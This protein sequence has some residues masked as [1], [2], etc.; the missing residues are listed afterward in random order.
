MLAVVSDRKFGQQLYEYTANT[1]NTG[2]HT[3]NTLANEYIFIGSGGNFDQTSST[4]ETTFDVYLPEVMSY[5]DYYPFGVE[6]YDRKFSVAATAYG[7]N[8]QRKDNEIYGEGNSY[9]AEFWQYDSRLGRRWN[10]DP[11]TYPTHSAY[12]T[13]NNNPIFYADP[14]GEEGEPTKAE[15]ETE[16][17]PAGEVKNVIMAFI[18]KLEQDG[19]LK[20]NHQLIIGG[21]DK[22]QIDEDGEICTTQN[23]S[24]TY[25]DENG[26]STEISHDGNEWTTIT[27]QNKAYHQTSIE[28]AQPVTFGNT[29]VRKVGLPDWLMEVLDDDMNSVHLAIWGVTASMWQEAAESAVK[30][31]GTLKTNDPV[32]SSKPYQK[33]AKVTRIVSHGL[34]WTDAA[35]DVTIAIDHFMKGEYPEGFQSLGNAATD[36]GVGYTIWAISSVIPQPFGLLFGIIATAAW[37]AWSF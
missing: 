31:T 33:I 22:I 23:Y 5:S 19:K 21:G 4:T 27:T 35:I 32:G 29:A 1:T 10:I 6:L 9:T 12:L 2:T 20:G 7:F 11:K 26:N 37:T 8:G 13:F 24:A 30:E 28:F 15:Q 16:H 14:L 3:Y 25:I 18:S 17:I 36:V 34:I